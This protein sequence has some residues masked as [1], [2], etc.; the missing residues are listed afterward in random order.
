M[1]LLLSGRN[2]GSDLVLLF[3]PCVNLLTV[4]VATVFM[5]A[6]TC[7][8]VNLSMCQCGGLII[9]RSGL[10]DPVNAN[11]PLLPESAN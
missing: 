10:V 2:T 3:T 9:P 4:V 8:I 1:A 5:L 6:L 11:Y 7:R